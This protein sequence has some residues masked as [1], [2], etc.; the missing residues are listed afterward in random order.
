MSRP[1]RSTAWSWRFPIRPD[2]HWQKLLRDWSAWW[3]MDR[4]SWEGDREEEIRRGDWRIH[5]VGETGDFIVKHSDQ[6]DSL[7]LALEEAG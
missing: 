6:C 3:L 1:V 2:C 5:D 7:D 4:P